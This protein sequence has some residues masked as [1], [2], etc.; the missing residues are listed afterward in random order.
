M[1]NRLTMFF[2]LKCLLIKYPIKILVTLTLLV[3]FT[4]AFMIRILEGPV[5]KLTQIGDAKN[6]NDYRS[7]GNCIWNMFVTMTTGKSKL[8]LFKIILFQSVMAITTLRLYS[9]GSLLFS[10]RSPA[11]FQFR[12][13]LF[14]CRILLILNHTRI[15]YTNSSLDL[16][17]KTKFE[18]KLLLTSIEHSST[19]SKKRNS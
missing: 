1:G 16:R 7:F 17:P 9:A 6:Y 19:S 10:P 2:S 3:A 13:S 4:L 15:K 14:S 12:S 11:L 8:K 18:L 5:N